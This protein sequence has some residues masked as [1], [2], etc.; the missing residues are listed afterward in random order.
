MSRE[1]VFASLP[2]RDN[3]ILFPSLV[4]RLAV[5]SWER[6]PSRLGPP[7]PSKAARRAPVSFGG[8]SKG[9]PSLPPPWIVHVSPRVVCLVGSSPSGGQQTLS[10]RR[11]TARPPFLASSNL[12][13]SRF[14]DFPTRIPTAVLPPDLPVSFSSAAAL[15]PASAI[16]SPRTT[17]RFLCG[18]PKRNGAATSAPSRLCL[19]VVFAHDFEPGRRRD[20]ETLTRRRIEARR[21]RP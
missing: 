2:S 12:A 18:C 13:I 20:N 5:F 6:P 17:S 14:P 15:P 4:S 9:S 21:G 3:S 16:T 10:R 7:L 11:P 1:K 8:A 19:T